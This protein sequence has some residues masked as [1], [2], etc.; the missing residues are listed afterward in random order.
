MDFVLIPSNFRSALKPNQI[1]SNWEAAKNFYC[2]KSE[3]VL[4]HLMAEQLS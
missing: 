1:K 2:A 3:S 4:D